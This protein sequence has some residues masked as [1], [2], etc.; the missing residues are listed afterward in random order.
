MLT[1][2][3]GNYIVYGNLIGE[4]LR[5]TQRIGLDTTILKTIYELC[6]MIQWKTKE[7]HGLVKLP[8]RSAP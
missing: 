1:D 3:K 4:P 8:P 5:E 6:R 2:D 7:A